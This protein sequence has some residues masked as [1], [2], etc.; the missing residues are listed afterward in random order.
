M[1]EQGLGGSALPGVRKLP[2]ARNADFTG[3]EQALTDIHKSLNSGKPSHRVQVIYGPAG[4]GKTE[5]ALEYAH[6]YAAEYGVIW[7]LPAEEPASLA[8]SFAELAEQMG[9]KLPRDAT[10]QSA[11]RAVRH[12][13]GKR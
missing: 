1:A 12:A 7:W 2:H 9:Q 3:R 13:L 10:V 11:C 8:A 4:V 6:R 5:L